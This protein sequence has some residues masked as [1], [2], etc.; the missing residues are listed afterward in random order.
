MICDVCMVTVILSFML[1]AFCCCF[2]GYINDVAAV[3]VEH[4]DALGLNLSFRGWD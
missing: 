3:D 2:S 4:F 1:P